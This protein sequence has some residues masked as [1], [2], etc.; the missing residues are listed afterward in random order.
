MLDG[1]AA[2]KPHRVSNHYGKFSNTTITVAFIIVT[3]NSQMSSPKKWLANKIELTR[4]WSDDTGEVPLLQDA[5]RF[6]SQID[7]NVD[8]V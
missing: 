1:A 3:K 8:T 5:A 2:T 4:W 6:T 7:V